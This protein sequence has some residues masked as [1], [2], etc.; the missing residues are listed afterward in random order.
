[1]I[2]SGKNGEVVENSDAFQRVTRAV[3][4][5]SMVGIQVVYYHVRREHNVMPDNLASRAMQAGALSTSP[6]RPNEPSSKTCD[7]YS[8][9]HSLQRSETSVLR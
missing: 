4:T 6:L 2:T 1:M 3:E 9:A 7:G 8:V 5:L